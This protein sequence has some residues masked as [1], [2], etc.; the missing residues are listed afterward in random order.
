VKGWS[1]EIRRDTEDRMVPEHRH[2]GI[3]ISA[4]QFHSI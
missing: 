4:H 1:G 3:P 2:V